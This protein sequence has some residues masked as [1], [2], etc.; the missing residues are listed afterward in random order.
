MTDNHIFLSDALDIPD[1]HFRS[2]KG[3]ADY[4]SMASVL[5]GSSKADGINRTVTEKDIASAFTHH[6][7]N[8]NPTTDMIFAEVAKEMVG[9]ARG[10]WT[11]ESPS[12]RLYKHNAFLLP[13]WR[14]KGIG[15]VFLN[16]VET[17]LREISQTHPPEYEKLLQVNLSQSQTG[18]AILLERA[19]YQPVRHFDLMVRPDLDDIP[20]IPLPAG[21]EIRPATADHYRAIWDSMYESP[22]E[23]WGSTEPTEEAYREWLSHPH[24]QPNLWQIAWD[25]NRN[26]PV[27]HVLTYINRSE[28]KQ[29]GQKRGYTEG[30]GVTKEWRQRGLARAL[31]SLSLQA[32]KAAGMNESAL[33]ADSQNPFGVTSFYESC[34]F[35]MMNRDTIYRKPC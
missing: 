17:R 20:D 9:Y 15:C 31:I 14:R 29:L 26:Q 23:E 34:G 28:N 12:L 10:W 8:C 21:L 16:W 2:F 32:Q 1:L 19:G 22:G 5:T 24:F 13:N 18:V 25:Q 35:Q 4:A 7:S 3:E 11:E 33:I 27:G 6:L 30:I